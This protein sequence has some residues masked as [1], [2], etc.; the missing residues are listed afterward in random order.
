MIFSGKRSG[1]IHIWTMTV[2]PGYFYIEKYSGVIRWYMMESKEFIS[3]IIFIIKSENDELVSF[4]VQSFT[5]RLSVREVYFL[6]N[7]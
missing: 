2:D 5:F 4:H 7:E 1:I 3:S 6:L